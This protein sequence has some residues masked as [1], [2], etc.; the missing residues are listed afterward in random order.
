MIKYRRAGSPCWIAR[1]LEARCCD[2]YQVLK[3][4]LDCLLLRRNSC[5]VYLSLCTY[6]RWHAAGA[7]AAPYIHTL[8][9]AL[10]HTALTLS[11]WG[12][13]I[14][15]NSPGA[16]GWESLIPEES[17]GAKR[18]AAAAR[19]AARQRVRAVNRLLEALPRSDLRRMLAGCERA[20]LAFADVLY[21]P[22]ERLSGRLFPHPKGLGVRRIGI[23]KAASC[24]QKPSPIHYSRGHITVLDRR[25]LKAAS[26]EC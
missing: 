24:L 25:G 1:A 15:P 4:E 11:P 17:I 12:I 22:R 13:G 18:S 3:A 9:I 16:N 19:A 6:I 26:C 8:T 7:T 20:E 10:G 5:A 23:T 14:A 2:C 21:T